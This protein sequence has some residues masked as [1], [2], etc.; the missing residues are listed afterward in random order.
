[1]RFEPKHVVA[2]V[3]AVSA[4]VVLAPV[5][6]MAATGTLVNIAD[7][8]NGARRAK[9][10]SDGALR[11]ESRGAVGAKT[12]N[13]TS[14]ALSSLTF[15]KLYEQ[16][17]PD[18]VVITDVSLAAGMF[19]A[20]NN[21]SFRATL[22]G[23]TRTSGSAACSPTAPGYVARPLRTVEVPVNDTVV[24]SFA[25]TPLLLP[26][27]EAGQPTCLGVTINRTVTDASLYVGGA[28]YRYTP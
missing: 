14:G 5:G 22:W 17:G 12:F 1:M 7:P 21:W 15:H 11:V 2:M 16:T 3:V 9:V 28:G 26:K 20:S 27:A 25:G 10:S 23:A 19:S 8:A 24:L 4:A 6:V 18:R 13:F